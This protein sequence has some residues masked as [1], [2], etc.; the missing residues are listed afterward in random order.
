VGPGDGKRTLPSPIQATS[1]PGPL[2]ITCCAPQ[3]QLWVAPW[4]P[5]CRC[6]RAYLKKTDMQ[7]RLLGERPQDRVGRQKA[8]ALQPISTSLPGD[9]P[10]DDLNSTSLPG[11][12]RDRLSERAVAEM[13]TELVLSEV[14]AEWDNQTKTK[15]FN[16][17]PRRGDIGLVTAKHQLAQL[18]G[19]KVVSGGF[20]EADTCFKA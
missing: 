11:S 6:R 13:N 3:W 4:C 10:T 16:T 17:K 5:M 20:I 7:C 15:H 14:P 1:S 19:A 9:R 2:S 8:H 12:P 18:T